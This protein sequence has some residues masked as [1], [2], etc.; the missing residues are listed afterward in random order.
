MAE[1]MQAG[2]GL[3]PTVCG[4]MNGAWGEEEDAGG[5]SVGPP[6]LCIRP[7]VA[8]RILKLSVGR[9]GLCLPPTA[10]LVLQSLSCCAPGGGAGGQLPQLH[11]S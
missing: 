7:W 10:L 9:T 5:V 4:W 3:V 2:P 8:L 6:V 11:F 1:D